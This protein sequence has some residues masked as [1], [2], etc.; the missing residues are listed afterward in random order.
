M[1]D[2]QE[3]SRR[4]IERA[5]EKRETLSAAVDLYVAERFLYRLEDP[6][7]SGKFVVRGDFALAGQQEAEICGEWRL[8]LLWA[9]VPKDS[10]LLSKSLAELS[11][12]ARLRGED[13][14]V[15]HQRQLKV[16]HREYCDRGHRLLVRLPAAVAQFESTLTIEVEAWSPPRPAE[17]VRL[18]PTIDG[19]PGARIHCLNFVVATAE[20]IHELALGDASPRWGV[21][22][23]QLDRLLTILP[24][25]RDDEISTVLAQAF[26]AW[27]T[28]IPER[29]AL[30]DPGFGDERSNQTLWLAIQR[31]VA[32]ASMKSLDEVLSTVRPRLRVLLDAAAAHLRVSET[33]A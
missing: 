21:A 23:L 33:G 27:G 22:C 6:G 18:M 3:V 2:A 5:N 17:N 8:Q 29:L 10:A 15:F 1:V 26:A 25:S 14:V 28:P 11:R 19:V 24:G 7:T 13:G 32:G 12:A 16:W 31:R 9:G 4:L 20:C 30:Q